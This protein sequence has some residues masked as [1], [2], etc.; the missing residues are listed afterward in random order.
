MRW[1]TIILQDRQ[2]E[3]LSQGDS[4]YGKDL[5]RGYKSYYIKFT[6]IIQGTTFEF[7]DSKNNIHNIMIGAT[8]AYEITLDEPV[9]NLRIL[10]TTNI[11]N[12]Q[13]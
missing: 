1:E 10:S 5:L 8:G 9:T 3:Y 2:L 4:I 7:T 6:D 12:S 13:S 11:I